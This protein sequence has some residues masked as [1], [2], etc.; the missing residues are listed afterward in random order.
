MSTYPQTRQI[1]TP[2]EFLSPS[3]WPADPFDEDEHLVQVLE[4]ELALTSIA[5]SLRTMAECMARETTPDSTSPTTAA[6]AHTIDT[7]MA[8][9]DELKALCTRQQALLVEVLRIC[10]PSTSKLAKA[11]RTAL[12]PAP[13]ETP[14]EPE[15]GAEPEGAAEGESA[16]E[17]A[18]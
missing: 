7:L 6:D 3:N 18:A 2:E 8:E 16:P 14:A 13:A 12:E 11:I 5:T 4:G 1:P 10:K 17:G 15:G 9:V